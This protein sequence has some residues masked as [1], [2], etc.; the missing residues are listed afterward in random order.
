MEL[1]EEM[2]NWNKRMEELSKKVRKSDK[3]SLKDSP[4]NKMI[5]N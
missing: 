1:T 4:E 2:I 3:T 5:Y